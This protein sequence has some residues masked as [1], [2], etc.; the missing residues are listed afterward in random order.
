M[1][2]TRA[3]RVEVRL[4]GR[5]GR[6]GRGESG[7]RHTRWRTSVTEAC[8]DPDVVHEPRG[9]NPKGQSQ[10]RSSR[11]GSAT[12]TLKAEA[13]WHQGRWWPMA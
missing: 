2:N 9:P 3:S 7:G 1:N 6:W 10:V 12:A 4:T 5:K 8:G 13:G 11:A